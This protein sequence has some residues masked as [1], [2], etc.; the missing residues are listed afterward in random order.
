MALHPITSQT[1]HW[2]VHSLWPCRSDRH[3][4]WK[5]CPIFSSFFCRMLLP[6][7]PS[8]LPARLDQR[9]GLVGVH[10]QADGRSPK[11][12]GGQGVYVDT[13]FYTCSVCWGRLALHVAT[14]SHAIGLTILFCPA[15]CPPYF[16][17]RLVCLCIA[18]WFC[19][20]MRSFCV[21]EPTIV[22]VVLSRP[23]FGCSPCLLWCSLF[24][25]RTR[26]PGLRAVARHP[27]HSPSGQALFQKD[28]G[29]EIGRLALQLSGLPSRS[30]F[31]FVALSV[32]RDLLAW[33]FRDAYAATLSCT[34]L[35]FWNG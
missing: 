32:S 10:V 27:S 15:A 35:S 21:R 31:K 30:V 23:F 22:H 25:V 9:S 34:M 19:V 26:A 28:D 20:C 17:R 2:C 1:Y 3:V 8:D 16:L 18:S 11:S 24:F 14:L 12:R 4:Y 7:P 29:G 6:Q 5:C 33:R 13:C